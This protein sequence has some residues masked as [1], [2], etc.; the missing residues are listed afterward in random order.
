MP[1]F[2][3]WPGR[4]KAGKETEAIV[5]TL[6]VF[7][8]V[9]SLLNTSSPPGL[10]GVDISSVL[11]GK[12]EEY[13]SNN[14]IL[15]FWRDGFPGGPLPA[16]FG[17]MDVAAV[18][19]GH[20][21]AW[22]YTKSAHYND[23]ASVYHDPPL[24][25]NVNVDPGESAPLDPRLHH[26]LITR[27]SKLVKEHKMSVDWTTPLALAR[28]P[29]YRPCGDPGNHCRTDESSGDDSPVTTY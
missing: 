4:I 10:D 24:L 26:D 13:D 23:D 25:F 7:P 29:T 28:D 18:K 16:P 15:F 6:D 2:A 22:F 11:F 1:A 14:R 12:E 19:V 20:I 8:T 3:R 5:S 27:I 9:V 17:R 21:K